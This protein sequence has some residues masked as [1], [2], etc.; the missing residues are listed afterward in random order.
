MVPLGERNGFVASL[1]ES[2]ND[3]KDAINKDIES[4]NT[5]LV[6]SL[7]NDGNEIVTKVKQI[8]DSARESNNLY[9]KF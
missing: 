8:I 4:H 1:T 5:V 3:W 6:P 7:G 9:R 2:G